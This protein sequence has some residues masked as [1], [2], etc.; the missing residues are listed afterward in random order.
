MLADPL[1]VGCVS[2]ACS[3][4]L[5]YLQSKKPE[6]LLKVLFSLPRIGAVSVELLFAFFLF[7]WWCVGTGIM[8][9]RGPFTVSSNGYFSSVATASRPVALILERG[10]TFM[11]TL[12]QMWLP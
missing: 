5:L 4:L 8:T 11:L 9:F 2:L 1:A 12:T 10:T 3:L 6:I 7:A